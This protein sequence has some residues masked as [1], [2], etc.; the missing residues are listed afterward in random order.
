M[1]S[2]RNLLQIIFDAIWETGSLMVKS[3]TKKEQEKPPIEIFFNKVGL[4]NKDEEYPK[5][6]ATII[7]NKEKI[8]KVKCPIGLG[9][10][11]FQKHCD[12]LEVFLGKRVEIETSKGI[13]YIKIS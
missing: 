4:C 11:D 7:K 2:E 8:Y 1:S 6:M 12:A 13:I 10:S 3:F 5:L 9:K